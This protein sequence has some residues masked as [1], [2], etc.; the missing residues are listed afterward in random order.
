MMMSRSK[1]ILFAA[2]AAVLANAVPGAA[3]PP[4]LVARINGHRLKATGTRLQVFYIQNTVFGIAGSTKNVRFNRAFAV[5]CT[6]FDLA[7]QPLPVTLSGCN[8]NY[9][10]SRIKR[11]S[12]S[13]KAWAT[14]T[15][16]QVTIDTFDGASASGTLSGTFEV[17][18][19]G[20]APAPIQSGK[21]VAPVEIR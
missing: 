2:L 13:A 12:A 9:Q 14:S 10:E 18:G 8:G 21:F 6:A 20:G 19:D 17:A 11:R 16:V 5:A 3:K 7:S 4:H 15:G 1:Q